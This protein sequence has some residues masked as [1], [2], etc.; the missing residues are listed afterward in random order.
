MP[1][2]MIGPSTKPPTT[3][4]GTATSDAW[5]KVA[6][7]TGAVEMLAAVVMAAGSPSHV[8]RKLSRR[9]S[10]RPSASRPATAANES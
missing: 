7:E 6:I 3:L 10:G 4:A 9:V 8:G 2:N 1:R 5:P